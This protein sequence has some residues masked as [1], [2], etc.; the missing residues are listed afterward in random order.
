MR[1]HVLAVLLL[2]TCA[3]GAARSGEPLAGVF[4]WIDANPWGFA[5]ASVKD[6]VVPVFQNDKIVVAP[7]TIDGRDV[8]INYL[9]NKSGQLYSLSWYALIPVADVEDAVFLNDAIKKSLTGKYGAA[10]V[11]SGGGG[12]D[13]EKAREVVEKLPE[14]A[15]VRE[16]L[17]KFKTDSMASGKKP[18]PA[19]LKAILG[20]RQLL[21]VVPVLF[22]AEEMMWD[23]GAV[24]VYASLLCS[25]DG[26]CYQHLNF[27][28]KKLAAG[29]PYPDGGERKLFS[30]TPLDRDQDLITAS[31]K[32][33]K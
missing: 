28:S 7:D 3:T 16:K 26:S 14:L 27:V 2:L 18:N 20:D 13:R 4:A 6:A 17:D 19:D 32:P 11:V 1:K 25:T 30:Y 22:Y 8:T 15:E 23:G 33:A 31:N 12:P 29:E 21:D 9:F 24:W 5:R 10:K